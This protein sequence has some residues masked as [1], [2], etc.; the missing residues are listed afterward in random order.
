MPA[1][2]FLAAWEQHGR[3]GDRLSAIN[4]MFNR[5]LKSFSMRDGVRLAHIT[6]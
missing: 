2:G 1:V 5:N 3:A 6:S 4:I